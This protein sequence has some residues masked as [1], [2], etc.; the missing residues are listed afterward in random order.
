MT[1]QHKCKFCGAPVTLEMD[2]DGVEYFGLAYWK[3]L[4]ACNRCADFREKKRA[5]E[6]Q[7]VEY[8]TNWNRHK[9]KQIILKA[10]DMEN[11]M[12]SIVKGTKRYAD[13]V[14]RFYRLPSEWNKDFSEQILDMPHKAIQILRF[15]ERQIS[16]RPATP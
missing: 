4:A 5:L 8:A 9:L 6:G 11:L 1:I 14:C 10:A 2:D 16:R 7:L 13:L 12:E 3:S 15:Y